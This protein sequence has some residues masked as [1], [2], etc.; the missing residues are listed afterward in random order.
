MN[1]QRFD[2]WLQEALDTDVRPSDD[3]TARV[4]D[5]VAATPQEQPRT[6][7]TDKRKLKRMMTAL[8]A[9]AAI[10]ILIPMGLLMMPKGGAAP[11]ADCAAQES[12]GMDDAA[13]MEYFTAD[14]DNYNGTAGGMQEE[15]QTEPAEGAATSADDGMSDGGETEMQYTTA[16]DEKARAE[17]LYLFGEEAAQVRMALAEMGREPDGA[18][19]GAKVYELTA[20]EAAILHELLPEIIKQEDALHLMLEVAE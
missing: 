9:C 6:N 12:A 16:S 5:R 11:A 4:M 10:V 18:E 2:K 20:E 19:N 7:N 15:R 14:V 17:T 13:D 8:A 1:E 3:F